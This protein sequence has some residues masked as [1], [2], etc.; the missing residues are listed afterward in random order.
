VVLAAWLRKRLPE[1]RAASNVLKCNRAGFVLQHQYSFDGQKTLPLSQLRGRDRL[2]VDALQR[3][4]DTGS[5]G[6]SV[7]ECTVAA[8]QA[9][10]G[11]KYPEDLIPR[12]YRV[13]QTVSGQIEWPYDARND[14]GDYSDWRVI[15]S[16]ALAAKSKASIPANVRQF[17]PSCAH[18][19]SDLRSILEETNH[20]NDD[21]EGN[22]RLYWPFWGVM[23]LSDA[24][25]LL[26]HARLCRGFSDTRR[27]TDLWGND[28][29]FEIFYYKS[30]VLM[31]ELDSTEPSEYLLPLDISHRESDIPADEVRQLEEEGDDEDGSDDDS[32]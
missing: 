3:A 1:L 13:C 30:A 31:V 21:E 14:M 23:W 16:P 7:L 12:R 4:V 19:R 5:A 24:T 32:E 8:E 2:L 22:R 29:M 20:D 11:A 15:F 27:E 25:L 6:L 17:L 9:Q 18:L 26:P 10:E 28:V